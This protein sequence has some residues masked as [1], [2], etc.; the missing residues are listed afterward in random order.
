MDTE[1]EIS[2][3][4]RTLGIPASISGYRYLKTAI[5]MAVEDASVVNRMTKTL[6]PDVAREHDTTAPRVERAIRHAVELACERCDLN[7]WEDIFGNSISQ[8]SGKPTNGQFIA[9][10]AEEIR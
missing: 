9:T 2:E 7:I 1:K 5:K 4:L 3:F 6:Y 10:A 8:K